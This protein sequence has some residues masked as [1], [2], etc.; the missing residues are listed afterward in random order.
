MRRFLKQLKIWTSLLWLI[1]F[2][3][4]FGQNQA[5]LL[6]NTFPKRANYFLSWEMSEQTAQELAKWDLVI[7]D[8]EHQLKNR[9]KI[10]K[11]RQINPDIT[12]LAYLTIQEIRDDAAAAEMRPYTPL[13]FDLASGIQ[14]SWWLKTPT[15]TKVGWWP[16]THLLNITAEAP[17][18]SRGDWSD[19]LAHF[20]ADKILSSGIWDGLFFDN[21]WNSLTEKVGTNLDI[22]GDGTAESREIIEKTYRQGMDN[23]FV[24]VKNLTGNKYLLM[25]NDGE[26]YTGLNG[27]MLE[28]F[29]YARGWAPMMKIYDSFPKNSSYPP[30]FSLLNAN[31]ANAGGRDDYSKMR[32][33]LTSSLLG[34][35]YYSF[36]LGDR[37]H[38]QTWWY[39]EYDFNLGEPAGG[40]FLI[41]D[42]SVNFSQKG[43]WRRDFKSG[44]ILVNSGEKTETIELNEEYEKLKSLQDS[45]VNDGAIISTATIAPQD[46]LILLRPVNK[47]SGAVFP[48]GSFA[49]IFNQKGASLRNGFFAYDKRFKGGQNI[50]FDGVTVVASDQNKIKIYQGEELLNEFSPFGPNFKGGLNLA[51]SNLDNDEEKEIIVSMASG[52]SEVRIFTAAG[53]IKKSFLVFP[54]NYKQ[55]VSLAVADLNNNGRQ[56]IVVG[57][58]KDKSLIKIFSPE[59]KLLSGGWHA[60]GKNFRGGVNLA[61]GDVNGDG[62]AEIIA[63]AAAGRPEIKIF[64]DKGRQM[65][66]SF[67]GA[68]A[69]IKNG[70][71]VAGADIDGNGLDEVISLSTDVFTTV[72]K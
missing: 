14:D 66:S 26:I 21:T 38:G 54:K 43:L 20:A 23:F 40:P 7:L 61:A 37:D 13:R 46:G 60:F 51:F 30:A 49:R 27:L 41:K 62:R 31:T 53:L 72:M 3:T 42:R 47:V 69:K 36:D 55:G 25:G 63:G 19:Y 22:N 18:D 67:L 45:A 5:V 68:S 34:N 50:Y 35:G 12:I 59:G 52:G 17:E 8:M 57:L 10:L 71:K 4:P 9:E 70:V 11:M 6:Q 44:M 2:F 56:E 24:Q 48:N 32:F 58:A 64:N 28:N 33:G 1:C 15:G 16:G 29:P 65:G 39:D